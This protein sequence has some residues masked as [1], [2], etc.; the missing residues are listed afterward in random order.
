M[1]FPSAPLTVLPAP[2]AAALQ[3]CLSRAQQPVPQG[4]MRF[5][6]GDWPVGWIHPMRIPALQACW[7][8]LHLSPGLARWDASGL[9]PAQ[10][11]ERI[12][13]V[14]SA[15]RER[16]AITGWRDEAFACEQPVSDPCAE[17][18]EMLFA[19]ER[20]AFRFFGL[21]SRAVHINGFLPGGRLLCGRRAMSKATD[22]GRLDNLAAGGVPVGE[23]FDACAQRELWEEAGVPLGLS[24]L[25]QPRGQLRST[26]MT[27]EGLHDE[28]LHIYHLVLPPGF[29]ASN[30]DGE[31]SEFLSFDLE[32]LAQRLM[33]DEFSVDAAAVTAWGLMHP[34]GG[35][36]L[37]A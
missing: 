26:R 24:A 17:R 33:R 19:L 15:L 21:R 34:E 30:Q 8:E 29:V 5:L 13:I 25:L 4:L 7:P 16:Q 31:V 10:R 27:P 22:P 9:A 6:V 2:L 14:A 35:A 1:K 32:S 37:R 3:R 36:D 11:S 28:V 23:A 20:A 12:G 18:G